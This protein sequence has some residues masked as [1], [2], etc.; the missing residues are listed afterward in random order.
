LITNTQLF[1]IRN[2]NFRLHHLL[3]IGILIISF[4]ISFLVRIQPANYGYE[5]NEFDPFF[6]F[7]ATE[8]V[9]ENGFSKYFEWHDE[10]SWYPNGRDVSQNSQVMLHITTA[11]AYQIFGGNSSLYDFTIL[12]PVVIGS[13]TA[14]VIFAL[15]RVLGGTTAGMF[16]A[17]FYSVS[18]PIILRGTLGWF[19]SEPLGLFYGLIGL[20]LFLS[21]IKSENKKI[22]ISKIIGGGIFLGFGLA[23]WG[24]I[25]FFIIPI[26]IF[27]L[28]LPFL[29]KDHKFLSWSVPIFVTSFLLTT[30]SFERPGISFIYGLGGLS[31]IIP[32]GFLISCIFVQ[33]IS[34]Q[35]NKTRNGLILLAAILI[36]GSSLLVINAESNFLPLPSF[37]YL[38]AINPF[39]ITTDPLV[40]SVSE[41]ATTNIQESFFFH[42]ILMIF[43]GLGIWMIFSKKN[44]ATYLIKNEMMSFALII[45]L[46]GVYVSSAFIRLELFSSISIIILSSIGLSI[47]TK[48]IFNH[49]PSF[50]SRINLT[51]ISYLTIIII[52]IIIP[53]TLPVNG[54]WINTVNIPPTILNGGSTFMIA[55]D[56]WKESL[57]WIK[58][59]TPKD[60]VVAAWWDYGYWITTMSE[61][62]TIADN[63][64]LDTEKIQKIAKIFLSSPDD[65]WAMLQEMDVDYVV[66]FVAGQRLAVDNEGEA[67]YVLQHGGDES[68]KQW[69]MRI[70]GEPLDKYLYSD[71]ISGTDYFWNNT[72]LGKMF[73]FTTL[74]YVNF[75][76]NQQSATYQPG[77]TPVYVKDIKYLSD[78]NGPLRLV[79]ASPSFN[80]EKNSPIIGVFVYEINKDYSP[81]SLQ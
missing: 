40:D 69:F 74:A 6:N 31:L 35:E 45:G 61:R 56:D 23:S 66:V 38:N 54:N 48:E 52:L 9:V 46:I 68:K 72:L 18:L 20:Y 71:A 57:E 44:N 33:K 30:I 42:S 7:R 12:F 53:I 13:L 3:I 78:G 73:P 64:T 15:V 14:I 41:H 62:T 8:F 80:A 59:N 49:K 76:T 27:I 63:A 79:H 36:I 50:G 25:Q 37:R 43:A 58:T 28:T 51:K 32:T 1:T 39:L 24:G 75:Q 16:A 5:L 60:S 47:L 70:A 34:K 17:L 67:L 4:S 29:R 21:G 55:T 77:F 26:G 2:F 81:S 22:V 11:I 65:A 10:L 19:K